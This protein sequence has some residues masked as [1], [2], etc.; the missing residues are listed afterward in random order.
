MNPAMLLDPKSFRAD[1]AAAFREP[2]RVPLPIQTT[3]EAPA[4]IEFQFATPSDGYITAGN[5]PSRHMQA[6]PQMQTQVQT[7]LQTQVQAQPSANGTQTPPINGF[8]SMI[9]RVN[10]VEQ[11]A[12]PPQPKRRKTQNEDINPA[13]TFA[14]GS[15]GV[16]GAHIRE[17]RE[18]ATNGASQQTVVDLTDAG[19]CPSGSQVNLSNLSKLIYPRGQVRYCRGTGSKGGGDLLRHDPACQAKLPYR[20]KP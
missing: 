14:S 6:E 11:R 8:G 3:T 1:A 16:L 15:G 20:S 2:A 17:K 10:N 12:F 19:R 7:Q 18:A 4:P 13:P 9:E 5:S